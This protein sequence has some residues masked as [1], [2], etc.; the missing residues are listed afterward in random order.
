MPLWST[1]SCIWRAI[2]ASYAFCG[3]SPRA[4]RE[5]THAPTP[6][7][8]TIPAKRLVERARVRSAPVL[9]HQPLPAELEARIAARVE[10]EAQTRTKRTVT[11]ARPAAVKGNGGLRGSMATRWSR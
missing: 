7:P 3:P 9:D 11:L 6:R 5:W 2:S 10:R 8:I 1:R 4:A